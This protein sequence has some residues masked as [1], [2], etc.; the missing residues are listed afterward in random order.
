MQARDL[1]HGQRVHVGAEPEHP[2]RL[3]LAAVDNADDT[4]LANAG[5]HL[6]APEDLEHLRDDT[7]RAMDVIFQFGVLMQ[8]PPP[9]GDL[10]RESAT[11]LMIGKVP[12][13]QQ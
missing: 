3:A 12:S 4:G 1:V 9:E 5:H 6:V 2:A 8:I 13:L 11:R 7:G 10:V